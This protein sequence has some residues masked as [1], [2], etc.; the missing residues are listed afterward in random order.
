MFFLLISLEW[1]F[2]IS[3]IG[4]AQ[5]STQ[6]QDINA[7][8]QAMAG[9]W[10]GTF[11]QSTNEVKAPTKYFHAVARQT[12]PDSYETVFEYYTIDSKNQTPLDAGMSSMATT[13]SSDGIATNIITGQGDVLIDAD[14]LK[15]EQHTFI[16]I[17]HMSSPD[18]LQGQGTGS[19]SV[20]DTPSKPGK[21]GKVTNF[22]STWSMSNGT[23]RITQQFEVKFK[24]LF[25]SRT[26]KI[27]MDHKVSKGSDIMGLIRSAG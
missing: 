3:G 1:A 20:G 17:V 16:D 21:K 14:T 27:T 7:F 13:V 15:S 24:I 19:I 4:N 25:F 26:F 10:I 2:L 11:D 6:P 22:S 5:Q 23:L 9:E 12:G 8:L 18:V